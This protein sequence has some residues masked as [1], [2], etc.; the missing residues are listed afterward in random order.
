MK[1]TIVNTWEFAGVGFA[2]FAPSFHAAVME[3]TLFWPWGHRRVPHA[4]KHGVVRQLAELADY[5][6]VCKLLLYLTSHE[7]SRL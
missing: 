7:F 1:E 5:V 3:E 4:P 2:Q 6:I